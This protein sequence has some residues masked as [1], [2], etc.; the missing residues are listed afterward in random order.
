MSLPVISRVK[1][2]NIIY[3]S[4]IRA[5]QLIIINNGN[6]IGNTGQTKEQD[7]PDDLGIQR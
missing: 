4:L 5:E 1:V 3:K 2:I 7:I 6:N